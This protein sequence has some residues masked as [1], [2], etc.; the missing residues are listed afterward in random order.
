MREGTRI[1]E[2]QMGIARP[3]PVKANQVLFVSLRLVESDDLL[4]FSCCMLFQNTA[5]PEMIWLI[6]NCDPFAC[7]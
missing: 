5:G 1:C 3:G 7:H 6:T 4:V 2:L